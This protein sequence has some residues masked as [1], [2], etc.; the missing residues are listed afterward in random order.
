MHRRAPVAVFTVRFYP[1]LPQRIGKICHGPLGHTLAADQGVSSL[2]ESRHG[3]QKPHGGPRIGQ[4]NLFAAG[5]Q[6]AL[7]SVHRQAPITGIINIDAHLPQGPHGQPGVFAEQGIFNG[8][9]TV[10]QGGRHQHPVG[11]AF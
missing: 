8:A 3:R 5:L 4:V 10:R 7:L 9:H 6:A 11:V 1:D 2:T